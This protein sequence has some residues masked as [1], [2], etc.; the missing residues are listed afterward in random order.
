MPLHS[1]RG[2]ASA[3]GFGFGG[4]K[5]ANF[6][7]DYSDYMIVPYSPDP[8]AAYYSEI[9]FYN[10]V[11]NTT[12]ARV[13][14]STSY[15]IYG[16]QKIMRFG[17]F[18]LI[19]YYMASVNYVIYNILTGAQIQTGALGTGGYDGDI[20]K[21]GSNK[22]ASIQKIGTGLT[23][24]TYS[25]DLTTGVLSSIANLSLNSIFGGT[26]SG[27]SSPQCAASVNMD[28]NAM[29]GA[30]NGWINYNAIDSYANYTTST[31]WG[32]F[33]ISDAGTSVSNSNISTTGLNFSR[34]CAATGD[35]GRT[36]QL[37]FDGSTYQINNQSSVSTQAQGPYVDTTN[38]APIGI[39][40]APSFLAMKNNNTVT[41]IKRLTSSGVT[42]LVNSFTNNS[43]YDANA[44]IGQMFKDGA[45]VMIQNNTNTYG[46]PVFYKY[47]GENFG[48]AITPVGLSTGKVNP[49]G[50]VSRVYNY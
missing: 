10:V 4:G 21:F 34:P 45:V 26:T 2:A 5:A 11:T 25:I 17:N 29:F 48:S 33:V 38:F 30:Y 15:S 28:A 39:H 44:Y 1:T 16:S 49:Y 47:T 27:Y 41:E 22:I 13:P 42:V 7:T 3:K 14:V 24:N 37:G 9:A 40:G 8:Q 20:V 12:T 19:M 31:A 50:R 6:I 46:Q 35:L 36:C 43:S 32:S 23:V 18:L